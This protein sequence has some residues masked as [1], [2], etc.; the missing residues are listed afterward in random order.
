MLVARQGKPTDKLCF[1]PCDFKYTVFRLQNDAI[2][3]IV[4]N[5]AQ[6]AYEI[7]L[8]LN[9]HLIQNQGVTHVIAH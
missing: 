2:G 6:L 4:Y 5:C 9:R 3:D 7:C 8:V 1:T